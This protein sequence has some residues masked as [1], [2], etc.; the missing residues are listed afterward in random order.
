MYISAGRQI[1]KTCRSAESDWQTSLSVAVIA[2]L[3]PSITQWTHNPNRPMRGLQAAGGSQSLES[4]KMVVFQTY[5]SLA[6]VVS[7]ALAA[8]PGSY[9]RMESMR[10]ESMAGAGHAA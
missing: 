8:D 6:A 7:L 3:G 9:V 2:G 10:G 1:C 4:G 5:A